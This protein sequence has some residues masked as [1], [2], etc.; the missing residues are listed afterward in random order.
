MSSGNNINYSWLLSITGATLPNLTVRLYYRRRTM[1]MNDIPKEIVTI[2]RRNLVLE[3]YGGFD[4]ALDTYIKANWCDEEWNLKMIPKFNW[5]FKVWIRGMEYVCPFPTDHGHVCR[6][7]GGG[8]LV[9]FNGM[10]T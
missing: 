2:L 4:H 1:T 6:Y 7:A 5:G 3:E 8:K 9:R 10:A